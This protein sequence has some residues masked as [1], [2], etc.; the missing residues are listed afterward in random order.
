[1]LSCKDQSRT[2]LMWFRDLRR[3][4]LNGSTG[5][6]RTRRM[7]KGLPTMAPRPALSLPAN[8]GHCRSSRGEKRL[9]FPTRRER[10]V[11]RRVFGYFLLRAGW[12]PPY[13][14][15]FAFVGCPPELFHTQ[16]CVVSFSLGLAERRK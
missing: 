5:L 15:S 3:V 6:S 7:S 8:P 13:L 2:F 12:D 1:M 16:R 11:G 9:W 4:M 10:R 14:D